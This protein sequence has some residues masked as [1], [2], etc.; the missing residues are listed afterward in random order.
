MLFTAEE[1]DI[2]VSE[3][4]H[5]SGFDMNGSLYMCKRKEDNFFDV[6]K[7]EII[8]TQKIQK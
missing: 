5:V 3:L 6:K 7:N 4:I 2:T 8:D 1:L